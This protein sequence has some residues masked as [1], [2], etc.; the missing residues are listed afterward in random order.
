MDQDIIV[1]LE[2]AFGFGATLIDQLRA[3]CLFKADHNRFMKIMFAKRMMDNAHKKASSLMS[4][5][6]GLRAR[7]LRVLLLKFS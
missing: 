4:T 1:L 3:I 6:P 5:S 7:H 2:K